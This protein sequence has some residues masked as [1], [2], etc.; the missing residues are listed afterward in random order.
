MQR[1]K[2]ETCVVF[3]GGVVVTWLGA[4]EGGNKKRG[5]QGVGGKEGREM[6]SAPTP[7]RSEERSKQKNR[8]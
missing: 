3:I 2:M 1:D 7:A 4:G 5:K 6:G 8:K